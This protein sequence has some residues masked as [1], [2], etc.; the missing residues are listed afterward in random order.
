MNFKTV[1]E[2]FTEKRQTIVS[3]NAPGFRQTCFATS[4]Y[5]LIEDNPS[6]NYVVS[7][8]SHL[9]IVNKISD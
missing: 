6:A 7:S 9:A 1:V 3:Q 8:S 2:Y 5:I 4:Y